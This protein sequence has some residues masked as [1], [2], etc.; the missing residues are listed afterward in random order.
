MIAIGKIHGIP[1]FKGQNWG[2]A[3]YI[4]NPFH[5]ETDLYRTLQKLIL[6]CYN[7][8]LIREQKSKLQF[9][10]L[11]KCYIYLN[12]LIEEELGLWTYVR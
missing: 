9:S 5:G 11:Q 3:V 12:G 10:L 2:F 6:L 4:N 7:K 8:K 1:P